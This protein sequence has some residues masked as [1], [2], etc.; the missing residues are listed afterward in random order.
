MSDTD[1][2]I[3]KAADN[4]TAVPAFNIPYIPM[5]KPVVEALRDTKTAGLIMVANLEL[6]KFEAGSLET[7]RDEY[8]NVNCR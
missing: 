3:Q 8:E 5:M 6:H 1:R 7:I 4:W 2:I